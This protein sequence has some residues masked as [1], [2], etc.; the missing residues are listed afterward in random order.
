MNKP[1][2]INVELWYLSGFAS[3]SD[4]DTCPNMIPIICN[5]NGNKKDINKPI[6]DKINEIRP[7]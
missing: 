5:A 1:T 7:K 3:M 2:V 6:I 4:L